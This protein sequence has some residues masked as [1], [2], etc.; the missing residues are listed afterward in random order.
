MY[1]ANL[2]TLI[3]DRERKRVA[4]ELAKSLEKSGKIEKF[5]FGNF[6]KIEKNFQLILKLWKFPSPTRTGLPVPVP[7][8]PVVPGTGYR[9]LNAI[10]LV[11]QVVSTL[12]TSAQ[13]YRVKDKLKKKKKR[14]RKHKHTSM[15]PQCMSMVSRSQCDQ[16]SITS[17]F[18][19]CW[20][21]FSVCLFDPKKNPKGRSGNRTRDHSHPKGVSYP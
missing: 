15:R 13:S 18:Y 6:W 7:V 19:I 3:T 8:L 4:E 16:V 12:L 1:S 11:S 14:K 5:P 10:K 2:H 20:S 21:G 17:G 9:D